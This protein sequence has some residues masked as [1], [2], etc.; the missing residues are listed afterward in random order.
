MKTQNAD[1]SYQKHR[2]SDAAWSVLLPLLLLLGRRKGQKH[3]F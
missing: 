2:H 1:I 3:A